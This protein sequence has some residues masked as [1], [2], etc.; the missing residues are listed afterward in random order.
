M[1]SAREY[2]P[3]RTQRRMII[4][5][6]LLAAALIGSAGSARAVDCQ[7]EKGAG[8]PWAWRQIDGKRCWY[9]GQPGM[10]KNRLRWPENTKMPEATHTQPIQDPGERERLLHSYWPPLPEAA[11]Q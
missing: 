3:I 5:S 6:A 1:K 8:Y 4:S 9:K 10:D 11:P 7:S 2:G